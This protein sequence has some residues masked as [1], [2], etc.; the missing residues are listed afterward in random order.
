MGLINRF[1][2]I[3]APPF[4]LI[5]LFFFL[6]PFYLYKLINSFLSSRFPEDM[7]NKVVLIVGASSGIGEH[8]AYKYA[9]RGA[10]LVLVAR[11]KKSL[12]D[13]ARMC[14]DFGSP[15]VL[16]VPADFTNPEECQ[17]FVN[18]TIKSFGRLDH[19]VN[20]AGVAALPLFEEIAEPSHFQAVMD[21]NFWGPVYTTYFAI[22]HLK[23]SRGRIV[24]VTSVS[25]YTNIP[26]MTIYNASKGA[27]RN[28]YHTLRIELGAEIDIT[29]VIPG[30]IESEIT[31]GKILTEEGRIVVDQDLRDASVGIVPI[32]RTR[33]FARSVV[34]RVC[35][36]ASCV[37]E[38]PWYLGLYYFRAFIPEVTEWGMRLF[39]VTPPGVPATE[40]LAK[41]L[42]DLP[43]VKY[44]LYPPP[45][46][47]P[48]IKR[49]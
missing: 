32:E 40:D 27:V 29:E 10:F 13:V 45:V 46:R 25:A 37:I 47:S 41:K 16:A 15:S 48:E 4:L 12:Q 38:P 39:Y 42:M 6:P 43:F 22:P 21:V 31:K 35:N 33:D 20:V 23:K 44:I 8:L 30:A 17:K 28:F 7:A 5:A 3:V 9:K 24:G 26:R 19:L 49:D 34:E 1:M 18:A 36:G 2:D 14:R 11:R